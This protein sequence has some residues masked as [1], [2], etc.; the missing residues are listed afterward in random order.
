[1]KSW[2]WIR[3]KSRLMISDFLWVTGFCL[4]N[5][6]R[7]WPTHRAGDQQQAH[8]PFHYEVRIRIV[9][10]Y[11]GRGPEFFC[12]RLIWPPFSRQLGEASSP[13]DTWG[14]KNKRQQSSELFVIG[15]EKKV[16]G[17]WTQCCWSAS[18]SGTGSVGSIC[19]WASR[20]CI[21]IH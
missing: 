19:F 8:D 4:R 6:Q 17:R 9:R 14:K 5:A 20:I 3:I 18:A 2:I 21:W 13:G 12:S 1:M 10:E 16:V 7:D 15:E 11:I